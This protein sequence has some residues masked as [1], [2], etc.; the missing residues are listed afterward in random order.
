M[1]RKRGDGHSAPE[2]PVGYLAHECAGRTRLSFANRK[3]ER[4]FFEAVCNAALSLPGV[5]H[6]EGRPATGSVIVTHTG[7]ASTVLDAARAR[8]VFDVQVQ[9]SEPAGGDQLGAWHSLIGEP[10]TGAQSTPNF[11]RTTTILTLLFM[12]LVQAMRGQVMPP[13]T[14][15]LWY[16]LSLL[17]GQNGLDRGG[18]GA[19]DGG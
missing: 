17:L 10:M 11:A 13:A 19:R 1:R 8:G 3:N 14:T 15:A 4:A 5:S 2:L 6:V 18:G 7:P 9:P 16:A 12:A